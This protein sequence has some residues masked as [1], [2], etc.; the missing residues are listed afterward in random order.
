[1][2]QEGWKGKFAEGVLPV[3]RLGGR[4][5]GA[6]GRNVRTDA[7]VPARRGGGADMV[8]GIEGFGLEIRPC[9][10]MVFIH[11][12]MTQDGGCRTE[13]SC[14]E[15]ACLSKSGELVTALP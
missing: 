4:E 10:G 8:G 13:N 2:T 6:N 5:G 1:M 15:V 7:P 11:Q 12:H 14:L 3:S 9:E